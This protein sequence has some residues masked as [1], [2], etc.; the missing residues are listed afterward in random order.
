MKVYMKLSCR[1]G[2]MQVQPGWWLLQRVLEHSID[3]IN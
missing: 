2:I 1:D 3:S